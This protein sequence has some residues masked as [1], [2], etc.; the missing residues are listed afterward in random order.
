MGILYKQSNITAV[1]INKGGDLPEPLICGVSPDP[2][3]YNEALKLRWRKDNE[4]SILLLTNQSNT[5]SQ[6]SDGQKTLYIKNVAVN[7]EGWY[8]CEYTLPMSDQRNV[9]SVEVLVNGL[10]C[11]FNFHRFFLQNHLFSSSRLQLE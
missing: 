6:T 11:H 8:E 2:N 4:T 10:C 7:E 1:Y 3:R 5:I 9:K